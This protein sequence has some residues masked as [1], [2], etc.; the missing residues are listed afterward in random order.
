MERNRPDTSKLK[1]LIRGEMLFYFF[2]KIIFQN[3]ISNVTQDSNAFSETCL[4]A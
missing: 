2:Q 4:R 1:N 3:D